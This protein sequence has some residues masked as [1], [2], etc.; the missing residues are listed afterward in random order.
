MTTEGKNDNDQPLIKNGVSFKTLIMSPSET[1]TSMQVICFF[2][3]QKNQHYAG[4]TY[5]VNEHFGGEI[6]ELRKA[7][8]FKGETLETLVLTPIMKQIPAQRLLLIGMGD[9]ANLSVELLKA[10]GYTAAKEAV[11]L[12]VTDFCFAPSLKD[13][14][15][16]LTFGKTAVSDALIEGMSEAIAQSA[17]LAQKQ[18]MKPV[19][20]KDINLLRGKALLA[21]TQ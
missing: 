19:V 16:V 8:I 11:K 15:L 1:F 4:G 14:G 13:A 20:L 2:D 12:E 6:H 18:M 7:G 3:F 9:P 10:V 5:A 17:I 21:D